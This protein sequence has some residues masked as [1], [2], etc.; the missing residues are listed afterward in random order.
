MFVLKSRHLSLKTLADQQLLGI[1]QASALLEEPA[2]PTYHYIKTL[3]L[4]TSMTG[5]YSEALQYHRRAEIQ[6]HV[7]RIREKTN[8][9]VQPALAALWASIEELREILKVEAEENNFT[10]PQD[11]DGEG[12]VT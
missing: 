5:D 8:P 11:E 4:L 6:Y 7:V 3:L 2:I 1:G 9:V 12:R 10:D